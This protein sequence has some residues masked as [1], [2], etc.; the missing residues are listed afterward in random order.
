MP[1]NDNGKPEIETLV[2]NGPTLSDNDMQ[3]YQLSKLYKM[4]KIPENRFDKE[5]QATWFGTDPTQT[6]RDEINFGRFVSRIR[7]TFSAIIVKP[8]QIQVSL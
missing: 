2:D 6:L 5:A 1:E 7:A 4:S 8:I 3:K